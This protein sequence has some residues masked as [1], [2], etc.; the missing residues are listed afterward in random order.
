MMVEQTNERHC[1]NYYYY[2]WYTYCVVIDITIENFFFFSLLIFTR[3]QLSSSL[4][5][6]LSFFYSS[7]NKRTKKS[8]GFVLC[9][10]K[11]NWFTDL[12]DWQCE[13]V[14]STLFILKINMRQ[15]FRGFSFY[16]LFIQEFN[17]LEKQRKT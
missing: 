8:D 11:T 10:K 3:K 17:E 4:S 5:S 2:Y 6:N 16:L 12:L 13:W 15:L 7:N 14:W 1:K 9:A